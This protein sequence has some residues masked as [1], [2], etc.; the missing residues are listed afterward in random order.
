MKKFL[1]FLLSRVVIFSTLILIQII[2]ILGLVWGLGRSYAKLYIIL[3]I[4]SFIIAIYIING[5]RNPSYKLSWV[6][7]MLVFPLFGSF[8]YL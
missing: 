6:L 7:V 3:E 5:N 2:A 4:L 1:K 8:F